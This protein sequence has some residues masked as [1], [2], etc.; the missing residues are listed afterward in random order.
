MH[1]PVCS[2]RRFSRS[3]SESAFGLDCRKTIFF[4]SSNELPVSLTG[5]GF[6]EGKRMHG[7]SRASGLRTQS[8]RAAGRLQNES[9]NPVGKRF[10][11]ARYPSQAGARTL[12]LATSSMQSLPIFAS[13]LRLLRCHRRNTVGCITVGP[14]RGDGGFRRFR[15]VV[16]ACLLS[17]MNSI[18]MI[19]AEDWPWL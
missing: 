14:T 6:N 13:E 12:A 2:S 16:P 10:G 7:T 8:M 18:G 5:E 9:M 11:E 4:A 19:G 3:F 1:V 17:V 15:D